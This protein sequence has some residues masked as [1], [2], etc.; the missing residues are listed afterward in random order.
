MEATGSSPVCSTKKSLL[1]P[2]PKKFDKRLGI[3]DKKSM[4]ICSWTSSLSIDEFNCIKSSL[5]GPTK[6]RSSPLNFAYTGHYYYNS[7]SLLGETSFGRIWSRT[8]SG[9]LAAISDVDV[10]YIQYL[11]LKFKDAQW[12]F[13]DFKNQ[14]IQKINSFCESNEITDYRVINLED[15]MQVHQLCIPFEEFE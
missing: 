4:N 14:N 2:L 9:S 1:Q 12:Q 15:I 10:P 7:G 6:L 3:E 11:A 5:T 8:T 13:S